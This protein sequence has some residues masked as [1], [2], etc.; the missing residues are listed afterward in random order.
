MARENQKPEHQSRTDERN[1]SVPMS[2]G[3]LVGVP[4]VD[5]HSDHT[6]AALESVG[7]KSPSGQ[8]NPERRFKKVGIQ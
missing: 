3:R 7:V 2:L 5:Q 4:T 6:H 1:S 8:E